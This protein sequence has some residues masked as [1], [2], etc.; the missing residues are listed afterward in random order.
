MTASEHS[1]HTTASTGY[2]NTTKA[3]END[4][5]PNLIKKIQ[6]FKEEMNTYLKEIGEIESNM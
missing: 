5:K 1:C 6:A 3:Q 4:L 2:P